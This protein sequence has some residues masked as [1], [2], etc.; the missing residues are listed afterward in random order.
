MK[1]KRFVSSIFS[2][3]RL[4]LEK[5]LFFREKRIFKNSF[6]MFPVGEKRFSSL[7]AIFWHCKFDEIFP[8]VS[9]HIQKSF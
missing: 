7:V 6:V 3:L 4:V 9:L 1:K 8:D 5:K 2:T